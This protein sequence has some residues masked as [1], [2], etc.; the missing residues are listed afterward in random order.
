MT[1]HWNSMKHSSARLD[2][3]QQR[4]GMVALLL[5]LL[6]LGALGGRLIH[7]N[8][9]LGPELVVRARKQQAGRS[10]IPARRGMIF[11]ARGRVVAASRQRPDVFVDP[12]R[13]EDVDELA[14]R[15]AAV[16]NLSAPEVAEK[17]R[18][19]PDSRYV[20]IARC[21]EAVDAEAVRMLKHPAVGLSEHA[22]RTYPLGTSLAHVLG[23]VGRDGHGLEGIE[24]SL[25]E[26]LAGRDGARATIRDARRRPLWR[27]E[28]GIAAPEDGGH[29]VLTL[30][31]EIQRLA[32]EGL[33]GT[34]EKFEAQSGVALV[35]APRTGEV[36][37]LAGLPAYDPND[38]NASPPEHWRNR[39][40]TDPTEAGS[41]FKSFVISGAL[42]GGFV[43]P[44]DRFD[45]KMGTYHKGR[46][47]IRDEHPYGM[48]DVKGIITKS[49]NIGM[50]LVV[51]RMTE[52]AL[53]DIIRAFGFGEKSGIELPGEAEGL[54]YP[55][56]RWTSYSSTSLAMGYEVGV[57]PIQLI[58]AYCALANDGVLVRPRVV[59]Q[60]L[61]PDGTVVKSFDQPELVRRVIP[62]ELAHY[63][64]RELL[65]SVV[66][67]GSGRRAKIEGY[68]VLG[69]T[70][71]AK[72]PYEN[73]RGYEPGAYLSSFVAAAPAQDPAV[74]V[75]VMVRRPQAQTGYFG[76]I[77]A[78]PAAGQILRGVL[79]Y[80]EIP[81][82]TAT[83]VAV[84]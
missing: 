76:S 18:R 23:F 19:R 66:E 57:T 74:V 78:A 34:L 25:D 8:A 60:L 17:M 26:H 27:A 36:L 49:S 41:T 20:V 14:E 10:V 46:R 69:K 5:V 22:V 3:T 28:H 37:A 33:A 68:Q 40:L 35:M 2:Q 51:E 4:R 29:V 31:A 50:T 13:V 39:A 52:Q 38:P 63:V 16:L 64:T 56:S 43:D 32:E 21:V 54:V 84:R 12:G 82:D 1:E 79:A 59:K 11:D 73:Q 42:G 47:V 6:A 61:G 67:N 7:I 24:L 71:T 75:L 9:C 30:D 45:C 15:L 70:G 62:S 55:V 53:H 83:T 44:G 77:V 72:L 80:L 81:P 65:L 58:T 48:M